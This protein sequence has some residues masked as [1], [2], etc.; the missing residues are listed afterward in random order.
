MIALVSP[1]FAREIDAIV[2]ADWLE[3]NLSNPRL[4]VVDVRKVEDYKTGHIPGAISLLGSVFYVPAKGLSNELPFMDDLSDALADAGIGADSLVVV[5]ETDGSRFSWA[6]RVAWTLAYAGLDNVAVLSGGQAAW[7]KAAKPITTE[8]VK[9]AKTK[10]SAMPRAK[11]LALKAD[12]LAAKGQVIDAR[13]YDTY[14]G[15]AKQSFVAQAGHLPGA[16]FPPLLLDHQRGRP[17]Q[18]EGRVVEVRGRPGARSRR[19]NNC[20]LRFRRALHLLVVDHEGIHGM[21]E[22]T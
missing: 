5:V 7:V 21:G 22:R 16:Y 19:G 10:F 2:T 4:A 12:V 15:L 9:K 18:I 17:C 6:T 1:L 3:A 8:V 20:L 14:F 13:A 11:Y